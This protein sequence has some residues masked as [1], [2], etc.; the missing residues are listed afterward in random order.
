M[1]LANIEIPLMLTIL[2]GLSTGI[3]SLISLFIKD[4]KKSY[5]FFALGLS[6]GVMIYVSFAELLST[7]V[8]DVGFMNANIAFFLGIAFIM[9]IDFII[10]HQY[11]EERIKVDKK[12][13]KLM[14]AGIFTAIGIAIHNLPEGLAVFVSS[15]SDISLGIPLAFAIA[16]HNIPEGIAVAVPILYATKSKTKAFWYSFLS[17]VAEPIGAVIGILLLAPFINDSVISL[18]L[19]FVA[20]IMVF[21]SFDELLPAS[22][23]GEKGHV[24]MMGLIIGMAMMALSL[25]LLK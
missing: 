12:D 5:L 24:P 8:A 22:F 23:K 25:Q 3:G 7:A 1:D 18:S 17:G 16:M 13:R 19:A 14:S 21:I 6:A 15:L 2:A 10:P 9:A 11:I 4:F 20:G